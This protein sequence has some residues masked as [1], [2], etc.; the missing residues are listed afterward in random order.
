MF[1]GKISLQDL[2]SQVAAG[3][4]Y[5]MSPEEALKKII[6]LHDK[7]VKSGKLEATP[8]VI[9]VP[10]KPAIAGNEERGIEP[11][12]EVAEET[13]PLDSKNL[14]RILGAL[15]S[16]PQFRDQ[17]AQMVASKIEEARSKS[18]EYQ[19]RLHEIAE[20][21]RQIEEIQEAILE[22][23]QEV[24]GEF[25]VEDLV[26]WS[27]YEVAP[28]DFK[29]VMSSG[30]GGVRRSRSRARWSLDHYLCEQRNVGDLMDLE[31]MR[32]GNK[33]LVQTSNAGTLGPF[34]SPSEAMKEILIS[35]DLSPSRSAVKFW[36]ATLQEE[37]GTPR[38]WS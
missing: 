3:G 28:K 31:L 23:D 7:N 36:A 29:R 24:A 17:F 2:G 21:Q 35:Q 16:L 14:D 13:V 10:A 18:E 8:Q 27:P 11:Q 20:L 1:N 33:W 5:G 12:P 4:I 25:E 38:A 26:H 19:K 9:V 22:A 6:S 32:D 34:E 37:G 30:N 15:A